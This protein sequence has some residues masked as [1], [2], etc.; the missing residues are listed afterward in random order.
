MSAFILLLKIGEDAADAK[1]RLTV[2][3][4]I[5]GGTRKA[6]GQPISNQLGESALMALLVDLGLCVYAGLLPKHNLIENLLQKR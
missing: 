3:N 2:V 1:L 6:L 4:S 5:H